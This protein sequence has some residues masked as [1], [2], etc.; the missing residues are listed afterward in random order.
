MPLVH[1][2]ETPLSPAI[3]ILVMHK[4]G[5]TGSSGCGTALIISVNSLYDN[6]PLF[7]FGLLTFF[8]NLTLNNDGFCG[9]ANMERLGAFFRHEVCYNI[10]ETLKGTNYHR[11]VRYDQRNEFYNNKYPFTLPVCPSLPSRQ[12]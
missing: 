3:K 6:F 11:K 10:L 5:H 4:S 12:R 7:G 2:I 1:A 8:F 9:R